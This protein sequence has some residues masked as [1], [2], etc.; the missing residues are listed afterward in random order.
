[1]SRFALPVSFLF[2][3]MAVACGGSGRPPAEQAPA[4]APA[5]AVASHM[6]DHFSRVHEVE[7]AVIRGDLEAAAEPARWLQNHATMGGLP[8]GSEPFVTEM[9]NAASAVASTDNVGNAAVATAT[10]LATCGRCHTATG[11]TPKMQEV[12]PSAPAEGISRHMREH[13]YAVDLMAEGLMR[14]SDALWKQGAEALK[15]SPLASAE[16]PDVPK[17]VA[18]METR[19]HELADRAIDA[20]DSGARTAIYGQIV[21]DCA[22]CHG[23]HGKVWGPGVGKSKG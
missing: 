20:T 10:M 12:T 14:P 9:R 7:E 18:E 6:S 23:S 4:V 19:V 15:T 16:L 13:Q 17:N 2:M 22:S 5:A 3:S 8:A 21:G 1:M 11:V